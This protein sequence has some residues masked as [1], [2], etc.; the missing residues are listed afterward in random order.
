MLYQ[1]YRNVTFEQIELMKRTVGFDGTR[2][3]GL[4]Y[5]SFRIRKNDFY[6][7]GGETKQLHYL[8]S[9]GIMELCNENHYRLT[10]DGI[11]LLGYVTEVEILGW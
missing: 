2:L 9:V 3:H 7:G 1:D 6:D 5:K 11:T 4:K 8:C 10:M